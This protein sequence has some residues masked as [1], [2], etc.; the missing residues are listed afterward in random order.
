MASGSFV[1]YA[2]YRY[3]R[4]SLLMV[5]LAIAAYAWHQPL[6]GPNGGTWLG[7]TLGGLAAFIILILLWLGIR[8]R[9]Y[10][11][12][13]GTVRGWLSAHI[14]LGLS[15]P[16]LAT[17]H[18]GFQFH[19]NIHTLAYVLTILAVLSGLWGAVMY[20]RN[21][22]LMAAQDEEQHHE[23]V[24]ASMR[25]LEAEALQLADRANPEVHDLVASAFKPKRPPGRWA[26]A[27]GGGPGVGDVAADRQFTHDKSAWQLESK[28]A[29]ALSASRDAEHVQRLR[30]LLAT[31]GR[32]RALSQEHGAALN[33]QAQLQVW[34]IFHVP[35]SLALLAALISHVV[36]VFFYR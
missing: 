5:V 14:W 4:L 23:M 31:I 8:K 15:L 19:W 27:F 10:Y 11:S 3:L 2:G 6:S 26:R 7:F 20:L 1:N 21:P 24:E 18:S 29:K 16:V 34:L 25:E 36:S 9:R 35:I 30:D 13:V 12:R 33:L 28:L 22:R 32:R 17:L